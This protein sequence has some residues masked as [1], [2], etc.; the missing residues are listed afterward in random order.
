M[1]MPRIILVYGAIAG[2]I[3]IAALMVAVWI[4]SMSN[5]W[6]MAFGF[7]T[8]F[9]ALSFVFVGVKRYRDETLGGVIGFW[10][11]LRLGLGISLFASLF[12]VAGWEFS[13]FV[14]DYAFV[15]DMVESAVS[16]KAEA[17]ASAT[18]LAATQAEMDDLARIYA[19][20]L[21]RIPITFTEISPV[22][23]VVVLASAGLLRNHR[24]M[25]A[26]PRPQMLV[27]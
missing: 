18:E 11:A 16:K 22:V 19:N 24:F 12:Y 14:T 17:G 3:L 27:G 7:L 20:P 13:L 6:G 15:A 9:I 1:S 23:L 5:E 26:R 21:Y 4:G 25:P 10:P 8:M 2:V